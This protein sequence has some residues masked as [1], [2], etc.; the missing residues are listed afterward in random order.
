MPFDDIDDLFEYLGGLMDSPSHGSAALSELDHALQCA[1]ELERR[2]P[3]DVELQIAGLVHD[4][5]RPSGP[6][7]DH[8]R[9]GAAAVRPVLG[10]RVAALVEAHVSAKRYLIATDPG[11]RAT[12]SPAS[13]EALERPGG[14]VGADEVAAFEA[15]PHWREALELRRADEAAR[16]PGRVVPGLGHWIMALRHMGAAR[17]LR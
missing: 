14:A 15:L 4:I 12:L 16:V 9:R 10:A 8:G 7:A 13:L 6:P 11:Y 3:D 5:G 1:A 17:R 2:C